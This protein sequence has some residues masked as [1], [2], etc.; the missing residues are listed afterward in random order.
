MEVMGTDVLRDI[1]KELTLTIQEN[2]S[3][4]WNLRKS[5]QAKM[6]FE[7]KVLLKKYKY[8][9]DD[10]NDPNNYDRS[11]KV[12]MEQTEL[13]ASELSEPLILK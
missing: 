9:P 8:P 7:I 3:V 1:A 12:I 6:R 10:P 5:V 13:L 2:T 11:I 4:D